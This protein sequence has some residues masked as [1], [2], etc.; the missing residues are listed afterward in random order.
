MGKFYFLAQVMLV[1]FISVAGQSINFGLY[2]PVQCPVLILNIMVCK[3]RF[4]HMCLQLLYFNSTQ[5]EK[6][7]SFVLK[8]CKLKCRGIATVIF[9]SDF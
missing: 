7:V 4:I 9:K 1:T 2:P 8:S 5:L 6:T 3:I